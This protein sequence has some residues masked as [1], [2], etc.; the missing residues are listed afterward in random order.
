[1][2]PTRAL[3]ALPSRSRA[4]VVQGVEDAEGE[5]EGGG[6]E[7]GEGEGEGEGDVRGMEQN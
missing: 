7:E 3:T 5:E 6:R 2:W 4:A 1:M